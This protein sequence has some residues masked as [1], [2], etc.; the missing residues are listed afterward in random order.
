[1]Y[2]LKL[3]NKEVLKN[4]SNDKKYNQTVFTTYQWISFLENNKKG[5]SIV[6][7]IS[8]GEDIVGYFVGL[9]FEKFGLKILASPF[10][11]WATCTMGFCV[12][13]NVDMVELINLVSNYAF[14]ELKCLYMEIVDPNISKEEIQKSKYEFINQSTYAIDL[15]RSEED[16]FNGFKPGCRQLIRQ[17]E[18]RGA[19]ISKVEPSEVFANIYYDQLIDVFAKQNLK[20]SYDRQKV[21]DLMDAYEQLGFILG[22][23]VDD[24]LVNEIF[25]K[26]CMGK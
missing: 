19:T 12:K 18:R 6:L 15:T 7:E 4:I 25:H 24:D 2:K 23:S 11:G 13:E 3:V 5:S 9:I 10:E 21:I 16:I 26:F 22:E 20:P 14:K 1:M 8:K 17:F